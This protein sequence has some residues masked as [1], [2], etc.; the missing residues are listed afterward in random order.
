MVAIILP[1]LLSACTSWKRQELVT[2]PGAIVEMAPTRILVTSERTGTVEL[3][4]PTFL[5]DALIGLGA[6]QGFTNQQFMRIAFSE[7]TEA[8]FR[9]FSL[10]RSVILGAGV[11]VIVGGMIGVNSGASTT[12]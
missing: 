12:P 7:I 3:E 5:G 10:P 1:S 4:D 2:L 11:I 6:P 9:G 8:S